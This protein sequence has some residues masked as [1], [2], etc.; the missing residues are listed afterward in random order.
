MEYNAFSG[1]LNVWANGTHVLTD[2][3]V[4]SPGDI[5]LAGFYNS[6]NGLGAKTFGNFEVDVIPEPAMLSLLA[7]GVLALGRRRRC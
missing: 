7:L 1:Q 3:A 2:M 4:A 5:S 6:G